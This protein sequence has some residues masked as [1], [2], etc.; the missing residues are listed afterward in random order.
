MTSNNED[1]ENPPNETTPLIDKQEDAGDPGRASSSTL[2]RGGLN[3]AGGVAGAVVHGTGHVVRG[4]VSGATKVVSTVGRASVSAAGY[5]AHAATSTGST[6]EDGY[7]AAL[8]WY[9]KLFLKDINGGF[10]D[11]LEVASRGASFV[12]VCSL[13]FVLPH[14]I[15]PVCEKIV[16]MHYYTSTCIVYFVYTLYL[17]TGDTLHFAQSGIGGTIMAVLNCWLMQGVMPGGYHPGETQ[18]WYIGSVW[19]ILFVFFTLWLNFDNITR[20][21]ALSTFVWYWM[22]F[23]EP[24]IDL[25]FARNFELKIDGV[26]IRELGIASV[27]CFIAVIA[28]YVPYPI[29]AHRKAL[30]H[31]KSMIEQVYMAKKDFLWYY[32]GDHKD[33]M[34]IT[35]LSTELDA[36]RAHVDSLPGLLDSAWYESFGFKKWIVQRRMMRRF[37]EYANA[38]CDRLANLFLVCLSETFDEQH[39]ELMQAIQDPLHRIVDHNAEVLTLCVEILFESKV[40]EDWEK[41]AEVHL[42][43]SQKAVEDLTDSFTRERDSLGMDVIGSS[44]AGENVVG[45]TLCKFAEMTEDF[46]FHLKAIAEC[47]EKEEKSWKQGDGVLGLF[48]PDVLMEKE[49]VAWVLR[50]AVSIIVAFYIGLHGYNRYIQAHNANIAGTVS[51]LL[52]KFAGS[53]ALKN[54]SRL[55]GVVIGIVLGNLL[56]ALF[57]W[58][59]WWGHLSVAVVLYLWSLMGLFMYYHSTSYATVGLLLV[60]F[61]SKSLLLKCSNELTDPKGYKQIVDVTVAVCVM[62]IVDNLLSPERAS[63]LAKKA[64]HD[65]YTPLIE[66]LDALFDKDQANVRQQDGTLIGLIN[67]TQQL[68]DEASLEPRF[69]RNPWPRHSFETAVKCLSSLRFSMN[70]MEITALHVTRDGSRHKKAEF[71]QAVGLESFHKHGGVKDLLILYATGVM[72]AVEL[73]LSDNASHDIF[74]IRM[75]KL[76]KLDLYKADFDRQLSAKEKISNLKQSPDHKVVE[77]GASAFNLC[78]QTAGLWEDA[79]SQ[80]CDELNKTVA[81]V[82]CSPRE[83]SLSEDAYA[84]VCMIVESLKSMFTELDNVLRTLSA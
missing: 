67:R 58:C 5:A 12:V 79:V 81:S 33:S 4:T 46:H 74:K 59:T 34:A 83:K 53:A 57:G 66:A 68:G 42:A 52:S 48:E 37:R 45:I 11:A 15:C 65:A 75:K 35:V 30:N 50:N 16:A 64:F 69:W 14:E 8:T 78:Y 7:G 77:T 54:L 1:L 10:G 55:Q 76:A 6:L 2:F 41:L 32:S 31:S 71:I 47:Q 17:H 19:G 44:V 73:S 9:D 82:K 21:F 20:I 61:G 3:A 29:F 13:P 23:L 60:V 56:Y 28:G 70:S 51:V 24:G 63:D 72:K 36:I 62:T 26:A 18:R 49:H 80:F 25:G 22:A 84:D 39:N 27:G 43:E 38:T 40:R